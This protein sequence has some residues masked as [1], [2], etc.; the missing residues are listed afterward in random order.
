MPNLMPDLDVIHYKPVHKEDAPTYKQEEPPVY[1]EVA[2]T[3]NKEVPVHKEE[4]RK[5]QNSTSNPNV[6]RQEITHSEEVHEILTQIPNAIT[7]WGITVV[8]FAVGILLFLAW[9]VQYPDVINGRITLHATQAPTTLTANSAGQIKWLVNNNEKI[10]AEQPVIYF[11]NSANYDNVL[12]LKQALAQYEQNVY[13]GG[14]INRRSLNQNWQL[15]ELQPAFNDLLKNMQQSALINN[16]QQLQY[17]QSHVNSEQ[18]KKQEEIIDKLKRQITIAEQEYAQA[19]QQINSR[20]RP[21]FQSGAISKA[22]L[23]QKENELLQI[24]KNIENLQANIHQTETQILSLRGKQQ[25]VSYQQ[26]NENINYQ[27]GIMNAFSALQSQ[28]SIWEQ[29]YVLKSPVNGTLQAMP[30]IE[31]NSNVTAQQALAAIIPS[32]TT[33]NNAYTGKL[34]IP[35]AGSGK[36]AIGQ[37]VQISLDDFS[38]KEYGMLLGEVS[39]ILPINT[40][41]TYHIAV[42]LPNG[43]ETTHHLPLAFK[44]SMQ[45]DASIITQKQRFITR[46]FKQLTALF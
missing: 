19:E 14:H 46:I 8:T 22:D 16:N 37:T 39:H 7:R 25:E 45:G 2:Q 44:H 13:R 11:Y 43:L 42:A 38:K 33:Q 26:N 32:D 17:Q 31:N 18:I 36:V 28:I 1:H 3:Y 34:T 9:V 23:E 21:L 10:V 27:N 30:S 24:Q 5:T 40:Q 6:Q 15:G 12:Q 35:T 29:R 4:V 20:H 41:N